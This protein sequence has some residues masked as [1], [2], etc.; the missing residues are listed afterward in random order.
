MARVDP[1][2]GPIAFGERLLSLLDEG[3]FTATYKYAVLLALTDLCLEGSGRSGAAPES[4]TTGQLA[5]KVVELYWPHTVPFEGE[6]VLR[7]NTSGQAEIVSKIRRFRG[8]HA[9]D[10]TGT[11]TEARWAAPKAFGRLLRA[12]EWTLVRYPLPKLQRIGGTVD[13]FIYQIGWDDHVTRGEFTSEAFDNRI[14]LVEGAGDHLVRLAGLVRPLVQRQWAAMVSQINRGLVPD[15]GLEEFLF[16]AERVPTERV[17]GDLREL[18]DGRCFYC[19]E[20]L[21]GPVEVDHF[22]PW[23]RYPDDG[24][25]NLVV[26]DA[27]CNNAKRHFLAATE[28]VRRWTGRLGDAQLGD[29]AERARWEHRPERT[30]GVARSIYLRLPESVKLWREG[31][32]FVVPEP[33]ELRQVLTSADFR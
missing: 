10:P 7:Q 26:A 16:G 24:L 27:R 20:R 14:L 23:A 3:A 33:H 21:R 17:R 30:L 13:P 22:I 18:Q 19:D 28:H 12:V 4:V 29:I 5:E 2:R 6:A 11:L 32:T 9:P 25:A 8:R 31:G 15:A 1:D